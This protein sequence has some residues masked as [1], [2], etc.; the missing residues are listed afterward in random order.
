MLWLALKNYQWKADIFMYL[1]KQC[2]EKYTLKPTMLN[3][4]V[5]IFG[6]TDNFLGRRGDKIKNGKP[7]GI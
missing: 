7:I 2:L 1:D 5:K 3:L 6:G 4:A